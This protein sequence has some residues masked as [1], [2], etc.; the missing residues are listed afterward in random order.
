L[1]GHLSGVDTWSGLERQQRVGAMVETWAAGE[2]RK[3][4]AL[5]PG[6]THLWYWRVHHG[7]EVDFLLER[8]GEVVGIEVKSGSGVTSS[9]LAGLRACRQALGRRFRLGVLLHSGEEALA[10]DEHTVAV[11]FAVFFGRERAPAR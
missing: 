4:L 2:L 3:L 5:Q 11:P 8:G 9:D 10:L 1:A 6:R 7:T